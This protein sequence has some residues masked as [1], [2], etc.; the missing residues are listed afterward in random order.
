[1][2]TANAFHSARRSKE[3]ERVERSTAAAAASGAGGD[4]ATAPSGPRLTFHANS[5]EAIVQRN[6][7]APA[8]DDW[9][10]FSEAWNKTLAHRK[11]RA[12]AVHA[13]CSSCTAIPC[14]HEFSKK[15]RAF[16]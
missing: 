14:S 3:R 1:M 8:P 12:N 4:P 13:L 16:K 9:V 15:K 2:M 6:K 5:L 7:D 10:T 11:V